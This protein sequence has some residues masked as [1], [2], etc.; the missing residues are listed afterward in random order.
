MIKKIVVFGAL[1]VVCIGIVSV[2]ERSKNHKKEKDYY[3]VGYSLAKGNKQTTTAAVVEF[4]KNL[5]SAY[6]D[7]SKSFLEIEKDKSSSLIKEMK[8][9]YALTYASDLLFEAQRKFVISLGVSEK[10]ITPELLG[11]FLHSSAG[12]SILLSPEFLNLLHG[13]SDAIDYYITS[14]P[15]RKVLDGSPPV[16]FP[17]FCFADNIKQDQARLPED[18]VNFLNRNLFKNKLTDSLYQIVNPE[19]VRITIEKSRGYSLNGLQQS[20]EKYG[21]VDK[22]RPEQEIVLFSEKIRNES[23][24]KRHPEMTSSFF[25]EIEIHEVMHYLT[26][27]TCSDLGVR[28]V[29]INNV[30]YSRRR[31]NEALASIGA[32]AVITSS[33][34]EY[35]ANSLFNDLFFS[36]S[37]SYGLT[38]DLFFSDLFS[39]I[40]L[41]EFKKLQKIAKT[42]RSLKLT[43]FSSYMK[44]HEHASSD[45]LGQLLIN[46]KN[47]FVSVPLE[48]SNFKSQFNPLLDVGESDI[49]SA[50][51]TALAK[52]RSVQ[53]SVCTH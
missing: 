30:V 51:E 24:L 17:K 49:L 5:R 7:L 42:G 11:E 9:R 37:D 40:S 6:E 10:E 48:Y 25:K 8:V 14:T 13:V 15:E 44:I 35:K 3:F 1:V 28:E 36:G 50:A 18:V 21:E 53:D 39:R 31:I 23:Y 4:E 27:N 32:I 33:K 38:F 46:G 26:K 47:M 16:T 52:I 43:D 2:F 20:C 29:R 12:L 41:S 45:S 19:F 34:E 22:R